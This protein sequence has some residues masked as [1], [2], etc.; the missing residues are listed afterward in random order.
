MTQVLTTQKWVRSEKGW[1][2]GVCQGIGERMDLSPALLRIAWL[3]SILFFGVGLLFYFILAICLPV[4][5]REDKA[6]QAKIL[7]VCARL[8]GKFDMDVGL[9]RALAV[10]IGLGSFG[11]TL[12]AYIILHFLIPEE[13]NGMKNIN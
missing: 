1:V 11:T 2:A 4:E 8:A 10:V 12:L 3:F 5:G 7:G 13:S 9:T 6:S